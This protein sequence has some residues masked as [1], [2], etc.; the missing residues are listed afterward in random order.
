MT[1][2]MS[3]DLSPF[4]RFSNWRLNA[5]QQ[6]IKLACPSD[7]VCCYGIML[8]RDGLGA[9]PNEM[10]P[11]DSFNDELA[12]LDLNDQ[13]SLFGLDLAGSSET[14]SSL[15]SLPE[16]SIIISEEGGPF[17]SLNIYDDQAFLPSDSGSDSLFLEAS[18]FSNNDGLGTVFSLHAD[19][20]PDQNPVFLAFFGTSK[21]GTG[22]NDQV[23]AA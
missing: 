7:M 18:P 12:S 1:P 2:S 13:A 17:G 11:D 6:S 5:L 22:E 21:G 9:L 3:L 10:D 20:D 19:S 23:L 8:G 14:D 15:F 4:S 16:D